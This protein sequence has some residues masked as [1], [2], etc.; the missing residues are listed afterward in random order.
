MLSFMGKLLK[1]AFVSSWE[2]ALNFLSLFYHNTKL[3]QWVSE[4]NLLF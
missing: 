4:I 3:L 2:K 1:Y